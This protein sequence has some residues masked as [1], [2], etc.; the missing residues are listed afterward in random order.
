MEIV[1]PGLLGHWLDRRWGTGFL[2]LVGF[3]LGLVC[4]MQHLLSMTRMADGETHD[5]GVGDGVGRDD[6]QRGRDTAVN[7]SVSGPASRTIA[8]PHSASL[9]RLIPATARGGALLI[10]ALA[11]LACRSPAAWLTHGRVGLVWWPWR[12]LRPFVAWQR[13]SPCF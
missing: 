7:G 9:D 10:V 12:S 8:R 13:S 2:A 3:G 1:L 6:G 5:G 4:G 11:G